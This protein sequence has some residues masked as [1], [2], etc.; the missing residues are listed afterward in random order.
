MYFCLSFTQNL[1]KTGKKLIDFHVAKKSNECL[2]K[3][4]KNHSSH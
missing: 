3:F 1:K 4:L 2:A